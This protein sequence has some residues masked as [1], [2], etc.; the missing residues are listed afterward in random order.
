MFRKT[1]A[2][3]LCAL[4]TATVSI[5][6]ANESKSPVV[7]L[8]DFGTTEQFVASMKGVALTLDPDLKLHDLTHHIE[9]YNIWQASYALAATIEFWPKDTVFVSVVDPGVGTKRKSVV[10]KTKT[11]HFIVTPDNGTLTLVADK[12]GILALREI[13]ESV[14]RRPGSEDMHTFHGRDVYVYTGA[15]LAA[16]LIDY[17]GVGPKLPPDVVR[18]EYQKPKRIEDRSVVGNLIHV[19]TPFGNIVTNIP[20]AL[21]EEKGLSRK[22]NP[23]VGVKIYRAGGLVF[24]EALTYANSFG[25][26]GIGKPLVYSDSLLAVGLAINNGSFAEVFNVKAGQDWTIEIEDLRETKN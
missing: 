13:D 23:I 26:V 12:F 19:E 6:T 20:T 21:L 25:F 14:N 7:L 24:D 18:L 5:M 9:P 2:L 1:L 10:A 4:T 8:T 3:T 17:A 11:G 16:G 22:T 15:K